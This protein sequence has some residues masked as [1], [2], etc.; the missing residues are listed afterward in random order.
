MKRDTFYLIDFRRIHIL[1]N[2]RPFL[3]EGK[4]KLGNLGELGRISFLFTHY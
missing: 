3:E 1:S 4:L 2:P